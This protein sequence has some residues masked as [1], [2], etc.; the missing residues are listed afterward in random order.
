MFNKFYLFYFWLKSKIQRRKIPLYSIIYVHNEKNF[1]QLVDEI[2]YCYGTGSRI[3]RLDGKILEWNNNKRSADDI[4]QISKKIGFHS[5]ELFWDFNS[6][7]QTSAD[8]I[9]CQPAEQILQAIFEDNIDNMKNIVTNIANWKKNNIKFLVQIDTNNYTYIEKILKFV[10]G[11]PKIMSVAFTFSEDMQQLV[12]AELKHLIID[13][14]IELK[15]NGY[16]VMNSIN[17]MQHEKNKKYEYSGVINLIDFNGERRKLHV[18]DA[19]MLI[20][21]KLN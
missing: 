18:L 1:L 8:F 6:P 20:M 3:L 16:P 13:K 12:G 4:I 21:P 14:L 10:A 9:W 2:K 7:L 19:T 11:N 17:K 15:N 5:V